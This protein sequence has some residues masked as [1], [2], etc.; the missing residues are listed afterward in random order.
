[1][2]EGGAFL[3]G[4]LTGNESSDHEAPVDHRVREEDEPPVPGSRLQLAAGFGA[5]NAAGGIF[6][7]NA[8]ADLHQECQNLLVSVGRGI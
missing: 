2:G 8:D 7:S 6:T 4:D 3:C 1:M 5:T